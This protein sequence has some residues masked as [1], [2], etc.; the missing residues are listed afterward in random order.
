MAQRRQHMERIFNQP[1]AGAA[2]A[3]VESLRV[4]RPREVRHTLIDFATLKL[5]ADVSHALADAFWNHIGIRE[6]RSI[7][8]AW[9]YLKVFGRFAAETAVP[10]RLVDV[11]R[12][13]LAALRGVA[14]RT[15]TSE[16][17]AMDQGDSIVRVH[18]SAQ[19][20]AVDRAVPPGSPGRHGVSFQ[21][22][23]VA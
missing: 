12:A 7:L 23:P 10:T 2:A 20:F 9:T 22:F 19:A 14:E 1:A 3:P 5:P 16:R 21:P 11:N 18:D 8:T 13:L 4:D 6:D 17:R 15:A